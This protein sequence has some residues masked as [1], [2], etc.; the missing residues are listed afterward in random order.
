MLISCFTGHAFAQ[1]TAPVADTSR[2]RDDLP[3]ESW[4]NHTIKLHQ[5]WLD[6]IVLPSVERPARRDYF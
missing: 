6:R 1:Q 2:S 3:F 5:E 4:L